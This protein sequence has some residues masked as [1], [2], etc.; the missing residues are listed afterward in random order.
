MSKTSNFFTRQKF[1]ILFLALILGTAILLRFVAL[2]QI[3]AGLYYDEAAN[4]LDA[5]KTLETGNWP[6]FYDSQGGKESL[7]M[8]LLAAIFY[9]A[10]VGVLQIR[11]L[12]AVVGVLTI[13]A[14]WWAAREIFA[15][16]EKSD[17][18]ALALLSAAVLATL[19]V[20]VHFSRGGYRLVTQPL[21]GTLAMAALWRGL[22]GKGFLWFVLGGVLL[23]ATM[24]TYSAA[25]FYVVLLILFFPIQCLLTRTKTGC[26]LS[27]YFWSLVASAAAFTIVF[28]PMGLY[29]ITNIELITHRANEVSVFNPTWNQGN[30]WF[31]L[32]DSTWRNFAGIIWQGTENHHWNLPGRPMLDFLTIPLFLTGL[33]VAVLRW[34]RPSYLFV[35]LWLVALFLPAILSYD[36]V[37]IFH[38]AMGAT[39]AIAMLVAIGTYQ[40]L[41]WLAKKLAIS[42]LKLVGTGVVLF[43]I[44]TVS[45]TLTAYDYFFRW[46]NSWSAYLATQP[47][48]LELVEEINN[49]AEPNATYIF[50][51][52]LRSG[53]FRHP[54]LDLFYNGQTPYFFISDHEGDIFSDLTGAV[55]HND[56]VRIVDWKIGRAVEAD[57]KRLI[58]TLLTM[59][60]QPL[61]ITKET[62]AYKIESFRLANN[63]IDFDEIPPMQPVE[64]PFGETLQ[65]KAFAFGPT[66]KAKLEIGNPLSAGEN[67]WVLLVWQATGPMPTNYKVSVR[68]VNGDQVISQNDKQLLNGFHLGTTEWRPGEENF[69]IYLLP[70]KNTGTHQI[71]VIAY[72]PLTNEEL[73]PGG[74][75]LP[76][77][78]EIQ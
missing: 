76:A 72:N 43:V 46:G 67:V 10:D 61:G 27:R 38:R 21:L 36:R 4:A 14:M 5:V 49:E 57:P 54:N 19:F 56:L 30:L 55:A 65:L 53:R 3:P 35:L 33:V 8:W 48:Y 44:L 78:I 51:F 25:R 18:V 17:T 74:I 16:D 7:W 11:L 73:L 26:F 52:D 50:P 29:L 62:P 45:G 63:A 32:F 13:I 1:E 58:P 12:A 70:L 40:I 66:G 39:P 37:P 34:K 6:A 28:L 22:R 69:D 2:N 42:R 59:R 71:Q 77:P 24:Y 23:G 9:V 47:F 60:G 31:A 64:I 68:L 75:V 41:D 20:H 15:A